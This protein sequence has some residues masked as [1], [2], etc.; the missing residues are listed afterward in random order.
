[1]TD[2]QDSVDPVDPV[3]PVGHDDLDPVGPDEG[4]VVS[5]DATAIPDGDSTDGAGGTG[6]TTDVS[7]SD[8]QS[9]QGA[10]APPADRD[11]RAD[12]ELTDE[13]HPVDAQ[14]EPHADLSEKPRQPS[15]TDLVTK[16]KATTNSDDEA[17]ARF[18]GLSSLAWY[19]NDTNAF[20]Q[21]RLLILILSIAVFIPFLGAFGLW[22]PW[23]THYGEVGRQIVERHD[24][25]STWWGSHWQDA[26]GSREGSFFYSKPILLMWMMAIGLKVFGFSE[27]G[28]RMGVCLVS[29]LGIVSVYSFGASVFSRR[30]GRLM[31]AVLGT[32]PFWFFLGRQAQTD[33]PFVGLMTVAMCF[34]M[35][36]VFGRDRDRPADRL[37]YFLTFGWIGLIGI[38]QI[39]LVFAGLSR[40]RG[41]NAAVMDALAKPL[42][43]RLVYGV[44][45]AAG[46]L[47][48]ALVL[49]LIGLY[50]GIPFRRRDMT[51]P[52]GRAFRRRFSW[53]ALGILWLPIIGLLAVILATTQD[54]L[55][56]LAGWFHWGPV[57][58][59][60][61]STCLGLLLFLTVARPVIERSRLYLL[62][63]YTFVGL[64]TLAKGLLGFM[65]PGAVLFFYILLTREW[66]MLKRVELARG[67]PLFVL[68]AFPWYASMLIRHTGAFWQRFFVHDHFKR[69]AT[70]VH[71]IDT[72]SFEHFIKWL[73]YGL[74][75]W[76]AFL[77]AALAR[78][79]A[80]EG[81]AKDDD[82][83]R[84]TLMLVLWAV[85]AFT[86]FTLSSTKFHHYIFP[87]VPPLALLIALALDDTLDRDLPS[88]WPLFLLAIP[89]MGILAWDI[90]ADPQ[91]LKN[92]FTYK[93]DRKWNNAD[94]DITFRWT[95][96]VIVVP[97]FLG[98]VALLIR[99][100]AVRRWSLVAIVSSGVM[101]AYFC[102]DIYMPRV[103]ATW[104]QKGVWDAYYTMCTR[105]EGPPNS[106]VMKRFCEEP[107]VSYKLNW[108]GETYYSQNEVIPIRDDDDFEHFLANVGEE[109]FFGVME[110]GRFNGGFKRGLPKRFKGKAC[111]VYNENIKFVLAKVPCAV[112]DPMRKAVSGSKPARAT[113]GKGSKSK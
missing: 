59:A 71:Q 68:V 51:T 43:P 5:K 104:S 7:S 38:P 16:T 64:A 24:W 66:R 79:F 32:S 80:G 25:I 99:N 84:A 88:P 14:L 76:V 50:G 75:P 2:Q 45:I 20:W 28:I 110:Y 97:A 23:E 36:G 37:S 111:V 39:S 86:L 78:V 72:G 1:M 94:W 85:I 113:N 56:G 10:G 74:F 27:W 106:N 93:Y 53:A 65:L 105:T 81:I 67:I 44:V 55:L 82:R 108:R 95:L 3:D 4:V 6:K 11:M 112:D 77:P 29:I 63:F 12:H 22:D 46:L 91:T 58:A 30:V 61:Y 8:S 47:V 98:S 96:A 31:A 17:K 49:L 9:L 103:S 90:L 101:L 41:P 26:G 107:V 35:M 48:L 40:W 60:I 62:T 73:G 69:L 89:T 42:G 109:T 13:V 87:V 33:M 100:R 21:D 70:G 92:L 34:F 15:A 54:R 52:Q 18:S 102:L 57:Q 19:E 83:S